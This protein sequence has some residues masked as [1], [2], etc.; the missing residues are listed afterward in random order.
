MLQQ[1]LLAKAGSEQSPGPPTTALCH[2]SPPWSAEET[3]CGPAT[4]RKDNVEENRS[5]LGAWRRQDFIAL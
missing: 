5:L 1:P 4:A 3:A 2:F